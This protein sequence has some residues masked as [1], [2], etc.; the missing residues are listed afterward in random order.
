MG[1]NQVKKTGEP[2][3]LNGIDDRSNFYFVHSFRVPSGKEVTA[4]SEYGESI[5][6]IIEQDNW[7][8]AQFHPERSGKIGEHLLKNFL[9]L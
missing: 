3:L 1:W 9:K 8:G 2:R 6:A 7:F 4:V 5:P